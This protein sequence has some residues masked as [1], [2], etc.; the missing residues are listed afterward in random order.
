L[1]PAIHLN[2]LMPTAKNYI[3]TAYSPF[4]AWSVL[5]T[6]YLAAKDLIRTKGDITEFKTF[7]NTTL[8]ETWQDKEQAV[9]L[10]EDALYNRREIFAKKGNEILVANKALVLLGGWDTQDDRIE[11]EIR[12]FAENGENWLVEFFVLY[13][14]PANLTLWDQ[15]E[16]RV[17]KTYTKVNGEPMTLTRVCLD[18]GGHFTDEVY[19]FCKRFPGQRVIPTKG[20]S[21]YDQ[22]VA[23]L[24]PRR[25]SKGVKLAIIGTDTAK[26]VV[27]NW[28]QITCR[29]EDKN[30]STKNVDKVVDNP[31]YENA[32]YCHHPISDFTSRSYFK[33][34]CSETK[35]LK[36]YKNRMRWIYDNNG[37]RNEAIDCFVGTL[38]A[39]RLSEDYFGL[40][41]SELANPEAK[42]VSF[43]EAAQKLSKH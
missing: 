32:G 18:S 9:I 1:L 41:L 29:D 39:L 15:L 27:Y 33:Q 42:Q 23:V 31:E 10:N 19:N 11:G 37:K 12:A 36:K 43:L 6:E 24:N 40:D 2:L 16:K 14:D 7:V 13:G 22:P 20:A 34:L 28:L 25:N 3:W 38:A 17:L 35:V 21:V 5:V 4:V 26:D 8:G 30:L